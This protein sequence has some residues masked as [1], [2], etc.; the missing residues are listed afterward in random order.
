VSALHGYY[1]EAGSGKNNIFEKTT[2]Y[3]D[4]FHG[5]KSKHLL[6]AY[7]LIKAIDQRFYELKVKSNEGK[8]TAD[9]SKQLSLLRHLRFK[10]FLLAIMGETFEN[11]IGESIDLKTISFANGVAGS[12]NNSIQELIEICKPVAGLI[13]SFVSKT[14]VGN[15]TEIMYDKGEFIKVKDAVSSTIETVKMTSETNPFVS[16]AENIAPKG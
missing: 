8:C 9:E 16:F 2:L 5:T 3:D 15:F 12:S 6:L 1:L 13:L 11:I 7:C 4:A 14:F 10:Y